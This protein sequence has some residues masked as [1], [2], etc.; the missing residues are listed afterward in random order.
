MA[1]PALSVVMG[2]YNCPRYIGAAIR[3]ILDQTFRDF[4][5]LIIDDG[6][7]DRTPA[8]LRR[9]AAMDGRIRIITVAHEG[10]CS[11][12]N[13]GLVEAAAPL[14]ANMDQD[15]LSLPHRF[16]AQIDF[17]QRHPHIAVVG[18]WLETMDARG[19][20]IRTF[21]APT[22]HAAID[23]LHLSGVTAV[24]HATSIYRADAAR[25][26]GGYRAASEL[27]EDLDLWLRIADRQRL[28][29]LPCVCFRYRVH[30]G[31]VSSQ[32]HLRQLAAVRNSCELAWQRRGLPPQ[33]LATVPWRP[34]HS[35]AARIAF[36]LDQ[37]WSALLHQ[38]RKTALAFAAKA[39]CRSPLHAPAWKLLACTMRPRGAGALCPVKP[40]AIL[41]PS[42]LG[43][44]A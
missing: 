1:A 34:A 33:P 19:R 15:D 20:P 3:S 24:S 43:P 9:F 6:S 14:I 37:G 2:A 18:G 44:F 40:P 26:A 10:I 25:A 35:R 38:H 29:T 12:R 31:S 17:L 27:A 42:I 22:D 21:T 32:Q 5:F 4:E 28:A 8:I 41:D 30:E 23:R 39:L 13:R 7:T 36:E 11:M 16:A